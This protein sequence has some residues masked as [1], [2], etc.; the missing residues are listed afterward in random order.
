MN[1][2]LV[3]FLVTSAGGEAD[4]FYAALPSELRT[5]RIGD[6][7]ST[8][9]PVSRLDIA[10]RL[11]TYARSAGRQFSWVGETAWTA[12]DFGQGRLCILQ[13]P[14]GP[15][16]NE[17]DFIKRDLCP[18]C[19]SMLF[20]LAA[21]PHIR[22]DADHLNIPPIFGSE[23][24]LVTCISSTAKSELESRG[25]LAGAS[26]LPVEKNP[27][28][29]DDY[30][31]L[32]STIDLGNPVGE[33]YSRRCP[34]CGNPLEGSAFFAMY[35]RPAQSGHVFHSHNEGPTCL[36]V[37]EQFARAVGRIA[38]DPEDALLSFVGWY[39]D[40]QDQARLPDLGSEDSDGV[41]SQRKER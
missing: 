25:L 15:R 12:A 40:D 20:S 7:Y 17:D 8:R 16:L 18:V 4:K 35:R 1:K 37:T 22:L 39:P 28:V 6:S 21:E 36:L 29:P 9:I 3:F 41:P 10:Q 2:Y 34:N 32:C 27:A 19:R 14:V 30:F 13:P 33:Q 11:Q 5:Y 31:L 38:G 23:S 24:G 26:T